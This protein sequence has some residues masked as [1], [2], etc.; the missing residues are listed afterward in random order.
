MEK[1]VISSKYGVAGDEATV[2][3]LKEMSVLINGC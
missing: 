3:A 2:N 1:L